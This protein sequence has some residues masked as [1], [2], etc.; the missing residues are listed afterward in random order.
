MR[1]RVLL[2]DF[3]KILRDIFELE[4]RREPA[5]ELVQEGPLT[6]FLNDRRD[7]D[8]IIV[9]TGSTGDAERPLSVLSRW[10]RARV[11]LVTPTEGEAALSELRLHTTELG[12]VSPGEIVRSIV[13]IGVEAGAGRASPRVR[14][15]N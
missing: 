3:P 1:V 5:I 13:E 12:R 11:M 15:S 8:V 7:P 14:D 9:G 6:P 10:P 2:L 4:M